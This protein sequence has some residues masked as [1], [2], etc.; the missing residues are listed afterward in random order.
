MRNKLVSV[1]LFGLLV[2]VAT[3][4]AAQNQ[5]GFQTRLDPV[6]MEPGSKVEV[7]VMFPDV[8]NAPPLAVNHA[9]FLFGIR[10]NPRVAP[11]V[12]P[13]IPFAFAEFKRE[14]FGTNIA[15]VARFNFQ[16]P[17]DLPKGLKLDFFLQ[18]L[19]VAKD[20][21]EYKLLFANVAHGILTT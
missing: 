17:K 6:K 11:Y 10:Y 2:L 16:V 19:T 8:N 14:K 21:K 13:A 15:L 12:I 3:D 1:L 4:A 20:G 5:A 18:G 7:T 9:M